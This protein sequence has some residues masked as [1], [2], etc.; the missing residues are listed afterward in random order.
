MGWA[1]ES[2]SRPPVVAEIRDVVPV[3]RSYAK[4]LVPSEFEKT[5]WLGSGGLFV[6]SIALLV[7]NSDPLSGLKI[8]PRQS[9]LRADRW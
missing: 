5:A 9:R 4:R 8:N 1:E 2:E 6:R 3:D 7:K